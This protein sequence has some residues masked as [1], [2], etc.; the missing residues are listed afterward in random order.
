MLYPDIHYNEEIAVSDEEEA[1]TEA[2]HTVLVT[3]YHFKK[4][5]TA[6]TLPWTDVQCQWDLHH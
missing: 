6:P 5:F 3:F 1:Q 4:V 2:N